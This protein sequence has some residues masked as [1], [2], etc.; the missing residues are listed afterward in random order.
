MSKNLATL[1]AELETFSNWFESN[2]MKSVLVE[3]TKRDIA[4]IKAAQESEA[5]K[6][7]AI[8]KRDA[9]NAL[10]WYKRLF[11]SA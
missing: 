5:R 10:P 2:P 8:A 1:E 9:F 6:Q 7:A 11:R 4:T 3:L